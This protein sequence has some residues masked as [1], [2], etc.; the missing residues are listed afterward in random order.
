MTVS[1]SSLLS[2]TLSGSAQNQSKLAQAAISKTLTSRLNQQIAQLQSQAADT[3]TVQLLQSQLD[4]A[5]TQNNAFSQASSQWLANERFLS[6]LTTQLTTMNTAATNSDSAGFDSALAAAQFDVAGLNVVAYVPGTQT[7]GVANLKLNGLNVQSSATYNL[8][9]PSGQA[10]AESDIANATALVSQI[11]NVTLQNQIVAS[12]SSNSL[13]TQIDDLTRRL[14]EISTN[15]NTTVQA[16]ISNLQQREQYQFHVIELG[17]QNAT[18]PN[19]VLTSAASNLA[20]VLASQPGSQTASKANPFITAL[21][22]GVNI[23]NQLIGTRLKA[24]ANQPN[25]TTVQQNAT[26]QAAAGALL[27]LFS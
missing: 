9:T 1:I 27:N 15:Q 2:A 22:T 6:D 12:S 18:K 19:S 10:Q 21:Q 4:A 8:S 3:T 11:T 20:S 23:A 7:D 26:S 24:A 17:L 16:Q 5:N 14:S 25:G 13:T